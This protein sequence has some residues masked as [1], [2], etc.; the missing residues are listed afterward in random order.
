M[1]RHLQHEDQE[2]GR[3]EAGDGNTATSPNGGQ[4]SNP[5]MVAGEG[6]GEAEDKKSLD[7]AAAREKAS[8]PESEGSSDTDAKISR[9]QNSILSGS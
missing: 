6:K 5:P 3:G 9:D 4:R 1:N 8:N 7:A 2:H